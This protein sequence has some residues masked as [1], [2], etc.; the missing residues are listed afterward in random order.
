MNVQKGNLHIV[1][2]NSELKRSYQKEDN[3]IVFEMSD[4]DSSLISHVPKG[5]T[6]MTVTIENVDTKNVKNF[7]YTGTD[8]TPCG[9]IAGWNY[10]CIS[11]P[12]LF[13]LLIND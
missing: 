9:D 11:D 2:N 1:T 10:Q 13:L 3:I 4:F 8:F 6:M 5:A 12:K 7:K